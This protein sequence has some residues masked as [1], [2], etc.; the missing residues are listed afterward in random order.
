MRKFTLSILSL[1]G[2]LALTGC[3]EEIH[4]RQVE[5]EEKHVPTKLFVDEPGFVLF[6]GD[7]AQIHTN[8]RPLIAKDSK[9]LYKSNK[10]GVASVSEDGLITAKGAGTATIKV[11]S[12]ENPDIFENV[13]V[14][15]EKNLVTAGSETR[16]ERAKRY[17]QQKD[18]GDK[19][20]QQKSIQSSKYL[21]SKGNITLDTVSIHSGISEVI[22]KNEEHYYTSKVRQDI[23]VSASNAFLQFNLE[24][25]ETRAPGGN[26]L[27]ESSSYYFFC[28]EDYDA[29]VYK[30]FEDSGKRTT[31]YVSGFT[32]RM[33]VVYS[34]LDNIFL[35]QRKIATGRYSEALETS[36]LSNAIGCDKGGYSGAGK[37]SGGYYKPGN[38]TSFV[39]SPQDESDVEIPAGTRITQTVNEAFHWRD[40]RIDT[41]YQEIIAEYTIG[42]DNFRKVQTVYTAAFIEDEVLIEYPDPKD[43]TRVATFIDVF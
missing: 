6:V 18:V 15:V 14:S 4:Y 12:K 32:S 31:V 26:P 38:E 23:T 5:V 40:G 41:S 43:Y 2:I 35:S 27:F 8:V 10:P 11:S 25:A 20:A 1:A 19:L 16:E 7:T 36:E 34:L 33:E 29:H 30:R 39:I 13:I 17:N 21:D 24:E 37:T 22:Y 9:I 28:N 3:G 42:T